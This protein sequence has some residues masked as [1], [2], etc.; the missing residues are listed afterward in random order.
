[1]AVSIVVLNKGEREKCPT[2]MVNDGQLRTTD[3]LTVG[4]WPITCSCCGQKQTLWINNIVQNNL[5][6]I[7]SLKQK[8]S[9][10]VLV[11]LQCIYMIQDEDQHSP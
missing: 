9:R 10:S 1:M 6:T 3:R 7:K 5:F 11:S 4:L 2:T 8:H